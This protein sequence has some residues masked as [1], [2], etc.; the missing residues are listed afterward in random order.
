MDQL[1]P[2]REDERYRG[3]EE[4]AGTIHVQQPGQGLLYGGRG[5]PP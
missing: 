3:P 2:D 1:Q 4:A 5:V